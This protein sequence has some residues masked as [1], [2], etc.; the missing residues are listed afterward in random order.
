MPGTKMAGQGSVLDQVN[1][2]DLIPIRLVEWSEQ[3]GA[4]VLHMPEPPSWWRAPMRW[5]SA[6]ITSKR[7]RLDEVGSTAWRAMD[8]HRT[9]AELAEDLRSTFGEQVEP[10]EERLGLLIK[11]LKREDLVAYSGIDSPV[12]EAKP[13][14]PR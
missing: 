5:I 6:F 9:V 1:L 4:V 11:T 12:A 3:D 7:L 8:G 2:L 14:A 10:A 13:G